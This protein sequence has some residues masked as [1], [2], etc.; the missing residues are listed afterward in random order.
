M[1]NKTFD[2][3]P[4][5]EQE[6]FRTVWLDAGLAPDAFTVSYTEDL[7]GT[8]DIKVLE[9]EV[10]VGFGCTSPAVF[11]DPK[12]GQ[13]AQCNASTPGVFPILAQHEIDTC[14]DAY[15]RMGW[16]KQ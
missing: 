14:S 16:V 5:S 6:D 12:T 9:R 1:A 3:L 8:G 4:R 15:A 11:K 2:D 10:M 13:V 7:V